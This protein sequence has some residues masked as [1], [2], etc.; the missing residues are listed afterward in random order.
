MG[1]RF[2]ENDYFASE[3]TDPAVPVRIIKD[4]NVRLASPVVFRVTPL[5]VDQAMNMNITDSFPAEEGLTPEA[6]Q[7]SPLRAGKCC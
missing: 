3:G 2:S 4:A 6:I 5:T 7:R 1:L